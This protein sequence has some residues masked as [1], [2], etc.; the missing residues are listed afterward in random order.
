MSK[1]T[2]HK[3]RHKRLTTTFIKNN[4]MQRNNTFKMFKGVKKE[5]QQRTL[6]SKKLLQKKK[7]KR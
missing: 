5:I 6:Y 2:N 3:G 4:T 7:K 1:M